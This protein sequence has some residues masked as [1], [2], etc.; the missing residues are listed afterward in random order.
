MERKYSTRQ[1]RIWIATNYLCL[2]LVLTLFYIGKSLDWPLGISVFEIVILTVFFI[3]FRRAFILTNFWQ[4]VHSSKKSLDE[5]EME[6]VLN[7]LKNSYTIFTVVCLV[8]IYG[9]ALVQKD[10]VDVV[11]AAGLLYLAHTLPAAI[12]GWYEKNIVMEYE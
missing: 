8:I 6:V 1:N 3:S 12:V 2:V 5:R 10:P 9:F 4:M 7:A 11:I